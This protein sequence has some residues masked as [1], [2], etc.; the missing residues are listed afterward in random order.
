MT[1]MS[2]ELFNPDNEWFSQPPETMYS[3]APS[4]SS[5]QPMPP[6]NNLSRIYIR[7]AVNT[8]LFSAKSQVS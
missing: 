8:Q 6:I 5:I 4:S 7:P 1:K 2:T 3:R